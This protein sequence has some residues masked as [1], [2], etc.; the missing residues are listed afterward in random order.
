[1]PKAG[2]GSDK[3]P[4]TIANLKPSIGNATLG[5]ASD[6]IPDHRLPD[7][8]TKFGFK[9]VKSEPSPPRRASQQKIREEIQA[10][11]DAKEGADEKMPNINETAREVSKRLKEHNLEATQTLIKHI[12]DELAFKGRRGRVGVRRNNKGMRRR[13]RST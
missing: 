4:K 3:S 11:Y 8:Q 10:L 13:R 9:L 7:N 12:A 2:P 5:P 6:A 1:M